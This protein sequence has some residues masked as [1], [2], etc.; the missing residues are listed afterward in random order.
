MHQITGNLHLHTNASDG[1]GTHDEVAT[2][3]VKAGLDFIIYTDHNTWTDGVEGWYKDPGTGK[4]VLRLMGQEINDQA[5]EPELNHMLCHFVSS[6]LNDVAAD[7]Q[8]LINTAMDRGG[9]TFLA[10]PLERPGYD[11]AAQIFPWISWDISGYTGVE[12][13]NAMTDAKWRLRTLLRG[14]IGGYLPK[15][16]FFSP[17]PEMLAKWDELLATGEKVVAIGSSDAH[18]W[19][20]TWKIFTRT[21]FPYELMFSAVNTHLLLN[22]PLDRD[23]SQA[24]TQIY[25]ALK[26]GHCFVSNDLVAA[27]RGFIF[28][29]ENGS[30]QAIMGDTLPLQGEAV[31]R[32]NSPHK[33]NI[34][35]IK[36]GQLLK[37]LKGKTLEWRTTEPG[38]FRVEMRRWHWGK[39][40]GW[41]YSNPIYVRQAPT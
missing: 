17:F 20:L 11:E 25:N 28:T 1:T 19:P 36:D 37:E 22:K 32:V 10:H 18:A 12:L 8:T 5:L 7:P 24:Q 31:L 40:R 23:V 9:L 21:F 41:V 16:V 33:A 34:R 4:E 2:A 26:S 3:A 27:P 30:T 13:W 38:V 39:T 29:G 6:N 15:A 14:L 35:L